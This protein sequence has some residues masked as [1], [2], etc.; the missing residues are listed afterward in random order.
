MNQDYTKFSFIHFESVQ[1]ICS[2]WICSILDLN[3]ALC[4]SWCLIMYQSISLHVTTV[5]VDLL[6]CASETFIFFE[7]VKCSIGK[8]RGLI[9]K[10]TVEALIIMTRSLERRGTLLD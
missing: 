9:D 3:V 2:F 4:M 5:L 10:T 1:A 7:A 6:V 8:E